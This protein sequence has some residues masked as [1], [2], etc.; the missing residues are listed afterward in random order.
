MDTGSEP[1]RPDSAVGDDAAGVAPVL[2]ALAPLTAPTADERARMRERVL[3]GLSEPA[4]GDRVRPQRVA[5]G[6][7]ARASRGPRGRRGPTRGGGREDR[8]ARPLSGAR[9]RLAVAAVALLALVGSLTGMSLLLARDALPGDALY[10]FKRTA[11]AAALGLTFGDESKALKHLDFAS[12]RI[13]ELETLATRY[14]G[15]SGA[16]IGSYLTALTDFDNDAAAG[17]RQLIALATRADGSQLELLGT[18]A[19]RHSARLTDV[20]LPAA[21]RGREAASL[22]LLGRIAG[23]ADALLARMDC[24]QITSGSFDDVG[25]LPA[26]GTCERVSGSVPPAPAPSPADPAPTSTPRPP[27]GTEPEPQTP[28]PPLPPLVP[29]PDVAS[30]LPETP[31]PGARSEPTEPLPS[32]EVPLPLP[33]VEVPPLLPG[34]PGVRIGG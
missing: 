10:G 24:Y 22:T 8:P 16:P 30:V 23:R 25:A 20:T 7:V 31:A 15:A 26:S 29:V 2:A 9:G 6:R 12:A 1:D 14:P 19:R 28:T 4:P 27:A 3:A 34:L 32:V 33:Q 13:T 17:S 18:W 21:V 11:E 5:S